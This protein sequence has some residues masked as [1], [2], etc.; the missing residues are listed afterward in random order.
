MKQSKPYY[1]DKI[2]RKAKLAQR[3]H[4]NIL[5]QKNSTKYEILDEEDEIS[6]YQDKGVR[7]DKQQK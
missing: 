7:D 1:G 6:F 3:I 5:R 4:R 2:E